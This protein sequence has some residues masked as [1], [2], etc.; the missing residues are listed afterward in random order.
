MKTYVC[1]L[2]Q[3][4]WDDDGGDHDPFIIQ[5]TDEEGAKLEA[6]H[7][8]ADCRLIRYVDM[9]DPD[10]AAHPYAEESLIILQNEV[11]TPWVFPM[12]I[13]GVLNFWT[14]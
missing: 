5:V 11:A 8:V 7:A 13:D 1:S 14:E 6:A 9:A 2:Q 10:D 3:E 4:N 12:E